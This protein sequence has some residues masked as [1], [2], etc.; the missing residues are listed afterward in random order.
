MAGLTNQH[1]VSDHYSGTPLDNMS[2]PQCQFVTLPIGP[3]LQALWHHPI[4][5]AKL[6]DG[7]QCALT[8]RNTEKGIQDYDNVCCGSDY[9][10]LVKSGTIHDNNMLLNMSMDGVQLY[11]D[12]ESDSQ[13][14]IS[15]LIDF[16]PEI[17]H[18]KEIVMPLGIIGG[19]DLPKHYDSFLFTTFSHFSACQK[20]GLHIW[21]SSTDTEFILYPWFAFGTADTVGMAELTGWVGHHRRNGYHLLCPMPG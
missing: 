1:Q 6:Q 13:F 10:D 18:S 3:Q 11:R 14:G 15:S 2:I 9:L 5:V 17:Q 20:Q 4:T 21:D 12:K 8:Q 7:L 19:P 16:S